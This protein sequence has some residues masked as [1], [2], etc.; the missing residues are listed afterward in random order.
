MIARKTVFRIAAVFLGLSTFGIVEVACRIGG[1][2][3]PLATTDQFAEFASVR[4]LF[5]RNEETGQF[6][7]AKNRRLYFADESFSQTKGDKERRIFFFG[8]S[9]VQ[10]RPFSI[11]TSFGTFTELGLKQVDSTNDWK[12]VNCGGVSYASYR[13]IPILKECLQ[14]EPDLFVVCTGHNE[15]LESITYSKVIQSSDALKYSHG[16]L[17]KLQSFQALKQAFGPPARID[18][19]PVTL[20]EE[21][22]AILDHQGGL[23]AYSR[24][25]LKSHDVVTQFGHNL[26]TM[27][28]LAR[29]NNVPLMLMAPP[30]NLCDCPPFKSEFSAN[31][32]ATQQ[33]FVKVSLSQAAEAMAENDGNAVRILQEIVQVDERF[34]F[35]WYQ[36]GRALLAERRVKEAQAALSRSRDEDV[37]PLRMTSNLKSVLLEVASEHGISL[38]DIDEFLTAHSRNGIIGEG[39]LVDHIHPSFRSNQQI[40]I[41]V[42]KKMAEQKLI[43]PI[44]SDAS[45]NIQ[46]IFD[47]HLQSLDDLYYLRGQ[48][49]LQT[50]KAWTQGRGDGPPLPSLQ[51]MHDATNN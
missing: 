42:I 23:D 10:G 45:K 16:L 11:P 15:F 4:P 2:G 33:Q 37:C 21:V 39:V 31:T 24:D 46:P 5:E 14:Y 51:E 32:S 25:S 26:K 40:A 48:R 41:A 13:L 18:P 50:L 38:F 1:W 9:T 20:P 7:I 43:P 30:S 29:D 47:D 49:T 19:K 44:D 6:R 34:A 12:V 28:R 36:L 35:S 17:S 27:I 22:D 3:R 8:G